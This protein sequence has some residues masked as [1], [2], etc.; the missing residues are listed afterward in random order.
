M[1][2]LSGGIKENVT[3]IMPLANSFSF[4]DRMLLIILNLHCYFLK[5]SQ[6]LT[7]G[8]QLTGQHAKCLF[9]CLCT[10]L[11][12]DCC[13]CI[14]VHIIHSFQTEETHNEPKKNM[15]E[16]D[17]LKQLKPVL[18]IKVYS[19]STTFFQMYPN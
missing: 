4:L 13:K 15:R 5:I 18:C 3:Y 1:Y 16:A 11:A 8:T 7:L 17:G 19:L 10:P 12:L 2:I 9:A 6:S 14:L